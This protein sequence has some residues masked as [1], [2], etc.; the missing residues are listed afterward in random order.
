MYTPV[1]LFSKINWMFFVDTLIQKLFSFDNQ[2][3][4]FS[5]WP[6]R[7]IGKKKDRYTHSCM[8]MC[9]SRTKAKS[10]QC[11]YSRRRKLRHKMR[12]WWWLG[13]WIGPL[14]R[15]ALHCRL[16]WHIAVWSRSPHSSLRKL[17]ASLLPSA[18]RIHPPVAVFL[19]LQINWTFC[20][21]P[22][23]FIH[24]YFMI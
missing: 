13:C 1:L 21:T 7:Y 20:W 18:P 24:H 15:M 9:Q 10:R 22:W 23:S 14:V 6:D 19:F 12:R 4:R 16:D 8:I 5:G 17:S 2:N 3:D 11:T